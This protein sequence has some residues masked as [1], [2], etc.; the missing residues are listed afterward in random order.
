[1]EAAPSV[2]EPD[3]LLEFLVVALDAPARLA[4]ST[5]CWKLMFRGSVESRALSF[6]RQPL[7]HQLQIQL[8]VPDANA[9]PRKARQQPVGRAL[10]LLHRGPGPLR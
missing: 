1:M 10:P 4:R 8:V 5:N 9:H 3:L 7:F 2:P 6:D